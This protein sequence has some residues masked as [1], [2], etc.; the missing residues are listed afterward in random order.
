MKHPESKNDLPG[1]R[2]WPLLVIFGSFGAK[3]LLGGGAVGPSPGAAG[4]GRV[5]GRRPQLGRRRRKEGGAGGPSQG[6]ANFPRIIH[7]LLRFCQGPPAF[8]L[9]SSI[10]P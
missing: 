3:C 1:L 4:A 2:Y 5:G 7:L 6:G 10:L 9:L 8:D